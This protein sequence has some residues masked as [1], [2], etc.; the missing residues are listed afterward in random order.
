MIKVEVSEAVFDV[1]DDLESQHYIDQRGQNR[2]EPQ[3][4]DVD[5]T[6]RQLERSIYNDSI[7]DRYVPSSIDTARNFI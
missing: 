6:S 5:D 7:N 3:V 1:E 4:S 2:N